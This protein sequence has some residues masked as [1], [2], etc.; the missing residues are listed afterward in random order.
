[1]TLDADAGARLLFQERPE[2]LDTVPAAGRPDDVDTPDDYARI[3]HLFPRSD[4]G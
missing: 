2:L 4:Q 3:V 1:M